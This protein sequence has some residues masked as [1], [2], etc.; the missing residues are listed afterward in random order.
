MILIKEQWNQFI[1]WTNALSSKHNQTYITIH[2]TVCKQKDMHP[3][4]VIPLINISIVSGCVVPVPKV[5]DALYVWGIKHYMKR[6]NISL[7][8]TMTT[9]AAAATTSMMMTMAAKQTMNCIM[10]LEAM[11]PPLPNHTTHYLY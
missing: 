7:P 9:T 10:L 6:L 8:K 1:T 5:L 4:I 11:S 2:Y 3:F